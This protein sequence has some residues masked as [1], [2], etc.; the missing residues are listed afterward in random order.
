[1]GA[2]EAG[3]RKDVFPPLIKLKNKK[4][5]LSSKKYI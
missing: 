2:A 1:M 5:N 3:F 4:S